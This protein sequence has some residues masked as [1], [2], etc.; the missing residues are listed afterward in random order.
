MIASYHHQHCKNCQ[1]S[2]NGIRS[3]C[4]SSTLK[5]AQSPVPTP[6]LKRAGA[7]V[8]PNAK[9][10]ATRLCLPCQLRSETTFFTTH[11]WGFAFDSITPIPMS[12]PRMDFAT[13]LTLIVGTHCQSNSIT[14]P[15]RKRVSQLCCR[16]TSSCCSKASGSFIGKLCSFI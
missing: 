11:S 3:R 5:L 16:L 10:A 8:L 9:P 14:S 6:T 2:R 1:D 15:T 13:A 4:E 7:S 12:V